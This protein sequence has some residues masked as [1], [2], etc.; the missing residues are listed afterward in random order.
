MF[1]KC[2]HVIERFYAIRLHASVSAHTWTW[3]FIQVL[4]P[5]L[6]NEFHFQCRRCIYDL[7]YHHNLQSFFAALEIVTAQF[8]IWIDFGMSF[9]LLIESKATPQL[10]VSTWTC[11]SF[12]RQFLIHVGQIPRGHGQI[13]HPYSFPF[14]WKI[15]NPFLHPSLTY[16]TWVSRYTHLLPLLEGI[17][18]PI[19]PRHASFCLQ[20]A[21]CEIRH[22][23]EARAVASVGSV[24]WAHFVH[25]IFLYLYKSFVSDFAHP[26]AHQVILFTRSETE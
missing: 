21:D 16:F 2:V 13:F 15:P 24:R 6:D 9:S 14:N 23:A 1:N 4:L 26:Y 20:S 3:I 8:Q 25:Y 5:T 12:T 7:R 18:G 17:H 10:F 22:G 19:P 11:V